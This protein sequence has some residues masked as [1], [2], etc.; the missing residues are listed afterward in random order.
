MSKSKVPIGFSGTYSIFELSVR[1]LDVGELSVRELDVVELSETCSTT[2]TLP[3]YFAAN[4][5][6]NAFE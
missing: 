4:I 2:E 1:E 6:L 3:S 5:P